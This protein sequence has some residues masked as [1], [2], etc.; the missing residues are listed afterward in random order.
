[1]TLLFISALIERRDEKHLHFCVQVHSIL[2]VERP[3]LKHC[4]LQPPQDKIVTALVLANAIVQCR[5]VYSIF[6]RNICKALL[7]ITG[8]SQKFV[9]EAL[10]TCCYFIDAEIILDN[11]GIPLTIPSEW[12]G[13]RQPKQL[14]S[15]LYPQRENP[16]LWDAINTAVAM[17]AT[18]AEG[19]S[20]AS[21]WNIVQGDNPVM[22]RKIAIEADGPKHYAVNCRHKLGNTI[23]KHRTLRAQ[24][25]DV[26]DVSIITSY[27][28]NIKISSFLQ[29]PYFEWQNLE[30]DQDHIHYIQRTLK[31]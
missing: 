2:Q 16:I 18:V 3:D 13:W 7:Q 14:L 4:I 31:L 27:Y 23:L 25:W 15:K 28:R 11:D 21:D 1:M 9:K 22:A 12:E 8:S 6:H 29:I 20:V 5:R 19:V 10:T 26:V 17:D 24:G 30:S